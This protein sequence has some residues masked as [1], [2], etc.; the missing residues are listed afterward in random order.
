MNKCQLVTID[1]HQYSVPEKF[2]GSHIRAA[3]TISEIEIFKD[4]DLVA[5][6]Q[7]QYG[8]EDSLKLDHY[9]DQLLYKPAAF[10]YAKAVSQHTFDPILLEIWN[11]LSEKHGKKEGNKQF[12]S[13]LLLRRTCNQEELLKGVEQA[14]NYGAIEYAAVE[15]MIRQ[16]EVSSANI[17]EREIHQFIPTASPKW[18]FDLAPYAELCEEVMS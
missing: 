13:I 18:R 10:S 15:L 1:N 7:R 9:L 14:L 11:R 3:V 16:A 17:D 5:L 2:V 8:K 6:H 12:T 4:E